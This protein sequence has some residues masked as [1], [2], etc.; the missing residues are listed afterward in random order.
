MHNLQVVAGIMALCAIAS[1]PTLDT[2]IE[3]NQVVEII[4][5][6]VT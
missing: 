3:W 1:A 4:I 6:L 5:R 2:L